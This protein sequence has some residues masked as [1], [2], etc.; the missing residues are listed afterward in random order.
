MTLDPR[1]PDHEDLEM[2]M[3]HPRLLAGRSSYLHLYCHSPG[4]VNHSLLLLIR[5]PLSPKLVKLPY[6]LLPHLLQ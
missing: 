4:R 6:L 5:L 2:T 3:E 1:H